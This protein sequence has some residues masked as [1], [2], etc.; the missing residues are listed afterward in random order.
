MISDARKYPATI[1]VSIRFSPE[2]LEHLRMVARQ[3]SAEL[4]EDIHYADLIRQ[5]VSLHFPL[6][7]N[8]PLATP[9]Q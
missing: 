7:Q 9:K 3:K 5:A 1:P 8:D 4:N 6:P 2:F